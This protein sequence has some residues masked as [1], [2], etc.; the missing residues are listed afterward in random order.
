LGV[1]GGNDIRGYG[2]LELPNNDFGGRYTVTLGTEVRFPY[3]L[4]FKIEPFL[5]A[6]FGIMRSG[7][8]TDSESTLGVWSPGF[9]LRCE[10][11]IGPIRASVAHGFVLNGA[12]PEHWQFYLG[13]G[14]E[15]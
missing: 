3:T 7:P 2:R 1:G 13:L 5:L 14:E 15:F 10:S 12:G 9:G 6:D 8:A 4:P 11:P